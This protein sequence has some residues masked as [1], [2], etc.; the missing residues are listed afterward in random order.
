MLELLVSVLDEDAFA[1]LELELDMEDELLGF[2]LDEGSEELL[3]FAEL[4]LGTEELE[5]LSTELLLGTAFFDEDERLEE[6]VSDDGGASSNDDEQDRVSVRAS[7]KAAVRD[8]KRGQPQG[9]PL[10]KFW[11]FLNSVNSGSDIVR[12]RLRWVRC[13]V[14][15]PMMVVLHRIFGYNRIQRFDERLIRRH[16]FHH[17]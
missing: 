7:A 5:S 17:R 14:I 11:K 16:A 3:P 12:L 10:H 15:V 13:C 8:A 6:D 4:E 1:E 9:L 2:E